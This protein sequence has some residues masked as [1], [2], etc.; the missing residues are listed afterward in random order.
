MNSEVLLQLS[1]H[2]RIIVRRDGDTIAVECQE[3][4]V[5]HEPS[6]WW[7]FHDLRLRVEN[8]RRVA[9]AIIEISEV[10]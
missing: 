8:A 1:E 3:D 6:P 10:K 9:D 5:N 7:T 2:R 4:E